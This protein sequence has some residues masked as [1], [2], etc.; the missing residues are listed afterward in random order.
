[1]DIIGSDTRHVQVDD[2]VH[3]WYIQTTAGHISADQDAYKGRLEF[4]CT[5]G[6]THTWL[7]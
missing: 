1:M 3:I 5:K 4:A 6:N 2:K 7:N